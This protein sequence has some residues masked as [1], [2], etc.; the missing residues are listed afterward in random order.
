MATNETDAGG[1]LN[2][3]VEVKSLTSEA[4]MRR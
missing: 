3:R 1:A 4:E 2:R